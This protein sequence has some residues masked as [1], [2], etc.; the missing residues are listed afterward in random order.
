[1]NPSNLTGLQ[2][3]KNACEI[4]ITNDGFRAAIDNGIRSICQNAMQ[5]KPIIY[6]S[7][8]ILLDIAEYFLRAM[9]WGNNKMIV[10]TKYY[11]LDTNELLIMVSTGK[12]LCL[13]VALFFII[14]GT[15]IWGI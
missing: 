6:I 12:T 1:L 5:A 2:L 4:C 11:K 7:L 14:F 3:N 15:K 13:V 10:D 8:A 9:F